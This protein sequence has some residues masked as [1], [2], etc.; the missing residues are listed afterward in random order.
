VDRAARSAEEQAA[1]DAEWERARETLAPGMDNDDFDALRRMFDKVIVE[2][3]AQL[4]LL[5]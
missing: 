1:L 2:R 3:V 5:P 4:N